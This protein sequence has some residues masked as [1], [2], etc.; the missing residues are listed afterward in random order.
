MREFGPKVIVPRHNSDTFIPDFPRKRILILLPHNFQ[1]FLRPIRC[2]NGQYYT[3][4]D[5]IVH[6]RFS[7]LTR[8]ETAEVVP[9]RE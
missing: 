4:K 2:L 8:L 7:T 1:L 5:E 6:P 3:L 9:F